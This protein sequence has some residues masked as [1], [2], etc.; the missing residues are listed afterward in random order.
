[1]PRRP[2][3][4][5]F[6]VDGTSAYRGKQSG[7]GPNVWLSEEKISCA[8]AHGRTGCQR[9]RPCQSGHLT[10]CGVPGGAHH[11]VLLGRSELA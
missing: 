4:R 2:N 5:Q 6:L 10:L 8:R 11:L 7:P 9:L 1:V 3:R